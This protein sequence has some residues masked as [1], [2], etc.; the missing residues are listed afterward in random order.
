MD[1][2]ADVVVE[3]KAKGKKRQSKFAEALSK[4]KPTFDPGNQNCSASLC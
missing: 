4:Q 3:K 2:E 1:C